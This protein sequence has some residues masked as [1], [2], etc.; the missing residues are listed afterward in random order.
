M[1][2]DS[3]KKLFILSLVCISLPYST[4]EAANPSKSPSSQPTCNDQC[5][6]FR[7]SARHIENKG[8]GYN[9][10]YTTLEAFLAAPADLWPVMPF[11]DLRGHIFNDG[12]WAANA[13]LG[14]RS[15]LKDRVY[16]AY[17]YYDYRD[18]KRKGYNQVS[19]GLETLGTFW[20]LR[21]NGYAVV[22]SRQSRP[23]DTQF[24]QFAGNN[25]YY[26]QKFQYALSGGNA[27]VGFYPLKMKDV[28]LYTGIGPY[29][30]KGP[31]GGAVWGGETRAKA[32]WKEYV[33][34]EVSYSYDHTFK[35]IVQGQ[36]FLSLP[37][38]P[39]EKVRESKGR[40]CMDNYL[41]C[42]RMIEPVAKNEIIPVTTKKNKNLAINP[43]TG[44][45]YTVYFVNNLSHSAG[46]YESPFSTLAA[47]ESAAQANDIIYIFPGDGTTTG[48][49]AGVTLK[50]YQ[51]LWGSGIAHSLNTTAG[52][53][54]VPAQSGGTLNGLVYS[55]TITN[56]GTVVTL[57]NGNEI[58]GLFLQN[59]ASADAILVS[60]KTN[61]TVSNCTIAGA[62]VQGGTGLSATELA[63][64]L[65]INNCILN[66]NTAISLSNS[67]TNLQANITNSSFSGG[68]D[69][70]TS[71]ILWNLSDAAQG[72][73]T[74]SNNTFDTS[75]IAITV[76]PSNTSTIAAT[77]NN[78]SISAGGYGI[79][80]NGSGTAAENINIDGN[81]IN[82]YYQSVR[83]VDSGVLIANLSNNTINTTEDY[84]I[85]IDTSAGEASILM[86][87]N[88]LVS[89]DSYTLYLNHSGGSL[90][91]TL[92]GNN[93]YTVEDEYAI[94]SNITGSAIDHV[95]N[96]NGNTIAGEYCWYLYQTVGNASSTWNNNTLH[97]YEYGIYADQQ[98]G[99]L[100]LIFNN[101]TVIS[102]GDE[103]GI[104]WA[105]TGSATNTNISITGNQI[106]AEYPLYGQQEVG[107]LTLSVTDNILTGY[108]PVYLN[109]STPGT[110]TATISDNTCSG[111]Y[112]IEVAQSAGTFNST[113]TNN[114]VASS[115]TAGYY[116]AITG[117]AP[118]TTQ[119][120]SGNTITSGA[121][122]ANAVYL[123]L[124]TAGTTSFTVTDN[125]LAGGGSSSAGASVSCT[126]LGGTQFLDL[127]NNSM[128]N[129]GGF[130]LS[131]SN[132][133][134]ATWNVNSNEFFASG[135]TP[136]S[137]TA[138]VSGTSVC[139]Q[140]N[141]NTAYPITGAY[142]LTRTSPATFTLNPPQGNI[143]QLTIGAGVTEAVCP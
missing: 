132:A 114:T 141:N 123:D 102:S 32:M 24:S 5:Q 42:Q 129:T 131:A 126:M 112:G 23:Y 130:S 45:P 13:G 51:K 86:T 120:I 78:N 62:N 106:Y 77:I 93:I 54:L 22:G 79:N 31:V 4:I 55:P 142:S 37:L 29:Y 115:G 80:I 133:C 94:Y 71:S 18:T 137:A 72:V 90:S 84:C 3:L 30:L 73:L 69:S 68:D 95:I 134:A 8:I 100:S 50:D 143:G 14:L 110:T 138:S 96:L 39:K 92:N 40:S 111:Y 105:A 70:T 65:T 53:I 36:V 83:I 57:G 109:L 33:G 64:T 16:G 58:S 85:E 46:T 82:T 75:Y 19:F 63:G 87:D 34:A 11:V 121:Y 81:T 88:T 20:D 74:A 47:A 140:L 38:G 10:G 108:T 9:T 12:H 15:L 61:A 27:E 56:T 113:V 99:T 89:S 101:N 118:N 7:I 28:T 6:P 59:G 26:T 135:S 1:L 139:M 122:A 124:P 35:N 127:S 136:V 97:P 91:A 103:E 49:N 2:N 125:V 52:A 128:T 60:N 21:L 117:G 119:L 25:I 48:L 67:T 43:A 44:Q 98:I 66:Q 17:A 116:Y 41:L 107:N 104:Y 76:T